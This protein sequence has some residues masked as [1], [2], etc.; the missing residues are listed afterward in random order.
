[1]QQ[2]GWTL[3]RHVNSFS[4]IHIDLLFNIVVTFATSHWLRTPLKAWA[5]PNTVAKTRRP[6]TC[7][8]NA[9]EQKGRR[10]NPLIKQY[11]DSPKKAKHSSNDRHSPKQT[12][13][14]NLLASQDACVQVTWRHPQ[15]N[16]RLSRLDVMHAGDTHQTTSTQTRSVSQRT[17]TFAPNHHHPTYIHFPRQWTTQHWTTAKQARTFTRKARSNSPPPKK[18]DVSSAYISHEN[19]AAKKHQS[20]QGHLITAKKHMSDLI[21]GYLTKK[22]R[23]ITFTVNA[24]EKKAEGRTLIKILWQPKEGKTFFKLITSRPPTQTPRVNLLASQEHVQITL[25]HPQTYVSTWCNA[26]WWHESDNF[27]TNPYVSQR[28]RTCTDHH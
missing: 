12:P 11:C 25:R 7:T 1:M 26:C 14:V 22:R 28:T 8:V 21:R 18:H 15:T 4:N 10:K 2:K 20:S 17:R 19:C 27:H 9:Q 23:P 24:Q 16:V 6:I 13:R 3:R 5:E